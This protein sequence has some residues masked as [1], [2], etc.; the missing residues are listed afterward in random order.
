MVGVKC[1]DDEINEWR[2]LRA[3]AI[4][5]S[6]YRAV[7]DAKCGR[8]QG[9]W[10]LVKCGQGEGGRKRDLFCGGPLWTTP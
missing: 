4:T 6:D 10:G 2:I 3:S 8:P 5:L 7:Y 1:L 9:E